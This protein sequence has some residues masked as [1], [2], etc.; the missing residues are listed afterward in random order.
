MF[1]FIGRTNHKKKMIPFL[2]LCIWTDFNCALNGVKGQ[3]LLT[4]GSIFF[5]ESQQDP[6]AKTKFELRFLMSLGK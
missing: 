1:F 4:D 3:A 2:F 6:M 5:V